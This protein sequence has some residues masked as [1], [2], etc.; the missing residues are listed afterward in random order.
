M[1]NNYNKYPCTHYEYV[2][3][4]FQHLGKLS[5]CIAR[6]YMREIKRT[7]QYNN[8][9]VLTLNIKYPV[10]NILNNPLAERKINTQIRTQVNE[11]YNYVS[12]SLYNQAISVYKESIENNFP[13]RAF[14]AIM[15]YTI[16]YND[17]C[18]LSLYNEKYEY[19]GGAH[20][21]TLR[22][23]YTWELCTGVNIYLH[24]FFTPTTDYTSLLTQEITKQAE[25]NLIDNPGIYFE[26]YKNLI[27]DTFNPQSFYMSPEGIT[28]YY[29]YYDIAPHST[30]IVEFTIPYETIGWY[31]SC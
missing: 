14:E 25:A 4:C 18:F 20:G 11:Y 7:F 29:Q 24:Y 13:I 28:I 27:I 10:V 12:T 22:S 23:S 2:N 9:D 19:T 21:N 1:Y 26:D 30:G 16:T 15:E 3:P 31:P 5:R 17:N 8:F 6:I